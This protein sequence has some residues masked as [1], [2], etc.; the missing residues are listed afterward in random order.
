VETLGLE[1]TP[2][3]MAKKVVGSALLSALALAA[4]L[5]APALGLVVS[6]NNP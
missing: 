2:L 3:G 1:K 6:L 5:L 4:A